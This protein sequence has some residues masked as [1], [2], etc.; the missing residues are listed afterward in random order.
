[1]ADNTRH[2]EVT[3]QGNLSEGS[4]SVSVATGVLN[5]SPISWKARTSDGEKA[6][7]PEELM[8]AAHAACYAMALSNTLNKAGNPPESL[9]VTADVTA[10]LT[11]SGLKV[12]KSVLKVR[13]KVAGLDQAGF[14]A[15][16]I[17]GEQGCPVSNALRG[18]VEI[19]VEATLEG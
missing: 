4:G 1:M 3:W 16:A 14:E 5:E 13:G 2:A 10:S 7:S 8:A 15:I 9:H 17:Q 18:N 12:T 19:T 6:T 11:D